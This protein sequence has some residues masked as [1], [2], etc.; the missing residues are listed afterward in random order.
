MAE[1]FV[2]QS[3]VQ[4]RAQGDG[5]RFEMTFADAGGRRQTI[6]LPADVAADLAP[7]LQ[8]LA[9]SKD[10]ARPKLTRMPK[11]TAVGRA[12]HERLARS[13]SMTSHHTPSTCPEAEN[14]WRGV[15]EEIEQVAGLKVPAQQ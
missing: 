5:R 14:P 13:A 11:L 1:N 4:T 3:L 8:A 15:R 12:R 9:P 2:A 7:V 6:S 10:G